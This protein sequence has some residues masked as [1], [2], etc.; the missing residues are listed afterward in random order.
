MLRD[1]SAG[2]DST[3]NALNVFNS[4]ADSN[5]TTKSSSLANNKNMATLSRSPNTLNIRCQSSNVVLSADP[6]KKKQARRSS[7]N[8]KD[9]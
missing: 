2:I 6:V 8:S 9:V 7:K 3:N 4:A 5:T 1:S